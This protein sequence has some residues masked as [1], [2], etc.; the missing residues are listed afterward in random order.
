MNDLDM[1]AGELRKLAHWKERAIKAE[2]KVAEFER[3]KRIVS[4]SKKA[5]AKNAALPPDVDLMK[6][7]EDELKGIERALELIRPRGDIKL[8]SSEGDGSVDISSGKPA[9][10]MSELD[11][12]CLTYTPPA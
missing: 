12:Y 4:L 1:A 5:E 3:E 9:R 10:K 2:T 7:S 8:G 6:C 11:E